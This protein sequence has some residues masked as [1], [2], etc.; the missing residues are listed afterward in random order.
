MLKF[1]RMF[2]EVWKTPYFLKPC[3]T[4]WEM[5]GYWKK[6]YNQSN[7]ARRFW[8]E[9][10]L[11]QLI[12]GSISIQEFYSCCE[13]LWT[14]YTDFVYAIAP[15]GGLIATQIGVGEC[16]GPN[17]IP[18][19]FARDPGALWLARLPWLPGF[20]CELQWCLVLPSDVSR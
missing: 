4:S 19:V 5:W 7:I 8:L 2:L 9:L 11:C 17:L 14:E 13:D 6:V 3:K 18:L 16:R 15:F 12:D 1:C 20:C 10:H